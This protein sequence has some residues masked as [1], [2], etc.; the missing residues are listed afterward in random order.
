VHF[1]GFGHGDSKFGLQG[2]LDGFEKDI[3]F[4]LVF[5]DNIKKKKLI[6]TGFLSGFS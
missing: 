6:D 5:Q 3:G 4:N 2:L 1:I